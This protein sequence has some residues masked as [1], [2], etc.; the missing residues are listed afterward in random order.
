[1]AHGGTNFGFFSG[2]NT[3]ETASDFEP[4][5]TSYDYVSK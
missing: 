5:I 4:D 2:A 3:G 1:M